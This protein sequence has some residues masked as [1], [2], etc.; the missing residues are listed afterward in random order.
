MIVEDALRARGIAPL[1]F[2]SWTPFG[3]A[4]LA[5]AVV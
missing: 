1:N 4:V 5:T 2:F 3:A